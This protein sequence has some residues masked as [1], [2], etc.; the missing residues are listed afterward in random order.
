[1]SQLIS[2]VRSAFENAKSVFVQGVNFTSALSVFSSFVEFLTP[3][4]A[5]ELLSLANALLQNSD[6]ASAFVGLVIVLAQRSLVER[7]VFIDS[8][9]QCVNDIPSGVVA[10]LAV[11]F[12]DSEEIFGKL[13]ASSKVAHDR[14]IESIIAQV[15]SGKL[16]R[17]V[18]IRSGPRHYP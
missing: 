1:V 9:L 4:E 2:F 13:M 7:S 6:N 14:L 3:E 18:L 12:A 11:S 5:T 16:S 10:N 8:L 17:G 15:S